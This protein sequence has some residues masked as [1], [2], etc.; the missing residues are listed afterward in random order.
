M[1]DALSSYASSSPPVL[2]KHRSL[3][4][5]FQEM[6][7]P[8]CLLQ[9]SFCCVCVCFISILVCFAVP[10][11]GVRV[12]GD[13]AGSWVKGECIILVCCLICRGQE[14][15]IRTSRSLWKGMLVVRWLCVLQD[16][17]QQGG[18]VGGNLHWNSEPDSWLS[19]VK[20]K[21][22]AVKQYVEVCV[23]KK[24]KKKLLT[25]LDMIYFDKKSECSVKVDSSGVSSHWIKAVGLFSVSTCV[26]LPLHQ[27][28]APFIS[29]IH[30]DMMLVYVSQALLSKDFL[31]A[32]CCLFGQ[33]LRGNV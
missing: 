17:I 31:M 20:K 6:K 2:N 21:T 4:R 3:R 8:A 19:D 16:V 15:I 26:C 1:F 23:K 13:V 14:F 10:L 33:H 32:K 30:H 18:G 7:K 22:S 12:R 5:F 11:L 9:K 25:V 28:R 29:K 24:E 27:Q